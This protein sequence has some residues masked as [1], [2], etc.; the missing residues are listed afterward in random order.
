MSTA[1]Q[2]TAPSAPSRHQDVVDDLI[3]LGHQLARLVVDQAKTG[4]LSAI[5]ATVAFDRVSRSVRRS[6][7]LARKL[8]EPRREIDRVAARKRIIRAVED[9]IQ[10]DDDA[11]RMDDS[12]TLHGELLDRLDT[13]DL[14]D[15]IG[16]RP[17]G[18]IITDIIRDL[19]LAA[20]PGTHPWKRRTPADIALLCR[21]AA[22]RVPAAGSAV[23]TPPRPEAPPP[24][25]G[26]P[27]LHASG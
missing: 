20:L 8:A 19:G 10:R 17:I 25:Q 13:P 11:D 6:I 12:G 7:L 18:E 21:R 3:D 16:T 2:T 27:S 1:S 26:T 4:V 24:F 22:K 5:D 23:T 14:E 9:T 15:E